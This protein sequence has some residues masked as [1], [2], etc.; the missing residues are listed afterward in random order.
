MQSRDREAVNLRKK[1]EV[2][3]F[4]ENLV[5]LA[6][7]LRQQGLFMKKDSMTAYPL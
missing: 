5:V 2:E 7:K 6:I 3:K 4:K 1:V